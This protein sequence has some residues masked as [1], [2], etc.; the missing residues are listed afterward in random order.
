[1]SEAEW[2]R[3]TL[4]PLL[5]LGQENANGGLWL[6]Q[7]ERRSNKLGPSIKGIKTEKGREEI[8]SRDR[9]NPW[10]L[11]SQ[12]NLHAPRGRSGKLFLVHS[13]DVNAVLSI[14]YSLHTRGGL[15]SL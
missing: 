5:L 15:D 8:I 2:D 14:V 12:I 9:E 3:R 4:E 1:L 6:L 11:S 13:V 7:Q 10:P